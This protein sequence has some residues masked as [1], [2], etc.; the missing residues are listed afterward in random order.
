MDKKA[1]KSN[2]QFLI[3]TGALAI[4][5]IC[6]VLL[7]TIVCIDSNKAGVDEQAYKDTYLI[8]LAQGFVGDS[9]IIHINDSLLWNDMVAEDTF[10]LSVTRFAKQ[11]VLMVSDPKL[12]ITTSFNLENEGARIILRK[13]GDIITM[14]SVTWK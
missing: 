13:Q 7:F 11:N 8:E 9:V 2:K 5:V 10:D 1:Q 14:T 6:I 3:G 4:A 12:D